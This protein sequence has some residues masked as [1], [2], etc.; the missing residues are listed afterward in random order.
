MQQKKYIAIFY[1]SEK[2]SK[3]IFHF[4]MSLFIILLH[5]K[6]L[7]AIASGKIYEVIFFLHCTGK[8]KWRIGSEKKTFIF[9]FW[10]REYY[11]NLKK[12]QVREEAPLISNVF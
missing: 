1:A 3:S 7:N 10:D 6:Q 12:M 5:H 2:N 8:K 11:K 4:E 9:I